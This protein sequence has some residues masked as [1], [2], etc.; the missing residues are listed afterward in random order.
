[1][2]MTLIK[3]VLLIL[4]QSF[5]LAQE[6][7]NNFFIADSNN[8]FNEP[9]APN[10]SG[11]AMWMMRQNFVVNAYQGIINY[12]TG[13]N[14]ENEPQNYS[15]ITYLPIIQKGNFG[16]MMGFTYSR[17]GILTDDKN[18][19]KNYQSLWI[20]NGSRYDINKNFSLITS[21]E[22]YKRGNST[23]FNNQT[24]NQFIGLFGGIIALNDK[25]VFF[26]YLGYTYLGKETDSK[27]NIMPGIE[28]KWIPVKSLE[29]LTGIP[30]LFACEWQCSEKFN[31][32]AYFYYDKKTNAFVRYRINDEISLSLV[33]WNDHKN[34]N[35]TFINGS[36]YRKDNKIY[37]FN[38]ILQYQQSLSLE[39]GIKTMNDIAIQFSGGYKKGG[40]IKLKYNENELTSFE[41]KGFFYAGM[42]IVFLRF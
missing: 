32:A 4:I 11:F 27:N 19:D 18:I 23:T 42:N 41:G 2:K 3:F 13:S 6:N 35:N 12:Q 10:S 31:I 34:L 9:Q 7:R 15:Y 17:Y 29:L 30:I 26:P 38:N 28:I 36:F 14:S 40:D 25:F 24:G 20:W 8:L 33:Y 22:Y 1:M 16:T 37:N 21:M 39:L 5:L